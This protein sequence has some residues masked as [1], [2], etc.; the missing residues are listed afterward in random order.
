MAALRPG[1][2]A[3]PWRGVRVFSCVCGFYELAWERYSTICTVHI[4]WFT[5]YGRLSVFGLVWY[6]VISRPHGNTRLATGRALD[7]PNLFFLSSLA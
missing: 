1:G 5:T 6:T 7:V 2:G 3:I 4:K